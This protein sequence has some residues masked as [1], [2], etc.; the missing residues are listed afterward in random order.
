MRTVE[1][2]E[3]E[4]VQRLLAGEHLDRITF[5]D[6][7][8]AMPPDVTAELIGG[9]VHMPPPAGPEHGDNNAPVAFWLTLYEAATPGVRVS[10][11]TSTALDDVAEPQPDLSLRVL[12][13]FGGQSRF[14]RRFI[15]GAP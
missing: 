12:Q 8:E 7:Y 11:N 14:D 13:E 2:A 5:H 15:D 3:T 9:I 1:P 4:V 6:R 10:I